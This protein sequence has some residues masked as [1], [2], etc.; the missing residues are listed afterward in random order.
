MG[1]ESLRTA[2]R[3]NRVDVLAQV[4]AKF[5]SNSSGQFQAEELPFFYLHAQLWLLIALA[6]IAIDAPNVIAVHRAFLVSIVLNE[7]DTHVLFKHF[8]K[9]ALVTCKSSGHLTFDTAFNNALEE[10]NH[11]PFDLQVTD[12]YHGTSYYQSRP[13]GTPEPAEKLYLDYDFDKYQVSNLCDLF[14]R[15]RWDTKDAMH[16]WIRN[17]DKKVDSMYDS[18]NRPDNRRHRGHGFSVNHHSYGEYLCWHALYGV[19]GEFIKKYPIFRRPFDENNP[20]S[21]W[22]SRQLL[23]K[24]DGLWLSD[25]T[26]FSPIDLRV[27]LREVINDQVVLTGTM[28]KMLSL[29]GIKNAIG[30]WTTV[31]ADWSSIDDIKVR[32]SSAL[33]SKG[34]SASIAGSLAKQNPFQ[35]YLPHLDVYEDENLEAMRSHRPY[36]PWITRPSAEAKLDE[37]NTLGVIGAMRRSRLSKAVNTFW[38]LIPKDQFGR[39]WI[40][41]AGNVIVSSEAWC[42]YSDRRSEGPFS[43]LRMQCKSDFIKDYLVANNYHLLILIILRRYESGFGGDKAK[44]WHSTAVVRVTETLDYE[45]YSGCM[46]EMDKL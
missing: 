40:D 3:L 33:V 34:K 35:A 23:T 28:E 11:S 31:D 25:G 24:E 13:E 7:N 44:Y 32:I 20:W 12:Q 26:D 36:I 42:Q 14:N 27:N 29:I 45:Y 30:E 43:A 18:G 10:V 8:A 5:P 1:A 21:D 39:S 41:S 38:Q 46:N 19:A 4:I 2:V 9:S 15:F 16:D 17:H 6:R 37:S 22:L